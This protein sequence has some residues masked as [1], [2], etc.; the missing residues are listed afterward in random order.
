MKSVESILKKIKSQGFSHIKI[1]LE[2]QINRR[3]NITYREEDC[4]CENGRQLCATCEGMGIVNQTIRRLVV[5]TRC[6]SCNGVGRW[7]CDTCDGAGKKQVRVGHSFGDVEYCQE[8]ILDNISED[9]KKAIN[10]SRFYY[11]GSVDS[12]LTFTIPVM[13]AHYAVEVIRAFKKLADKNGAGLDVAGAGM[14]IAVLKEGC[15]GQYPVRGVILD[16]DKLDNFITQVTKLL[17]AMFLLGSGGS[18]SRPFNYRRPQI[19][20]EKYSAIHVLN[21]CLEF[22]LFETCYDR[23]EAIYEFFGVISKALEFYANPDKKVESIGKTYPFVA[24]GGTKKFLQTKEQAQI[25]KRQLKYLKPEGL[26]IAEIEQTRGVKVSV[27]EADNA[28]QEKIARLKA[29]FTE[30]VK[31]YEYSLNRPLNSSEERQLAQLRAE[32][33]DWCRGWTEADM[34]AMVVGITSKK[35]KEKDFIASGLKRVVNV[36]YTVST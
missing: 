11:D 29:L 25:I 21:G 14:H 5:P 33:R 13:D 23:P 36:A 10:Y 34:K 19:T 17:P 16:G 3:S 26:K 20:N 30:H 4:S 32:N 8:Y 1:E 35:P 2:G 9:C 22:R 7:R 15:G 12:E 31:I 27:K 18:Y 6:E 28:V 24:T